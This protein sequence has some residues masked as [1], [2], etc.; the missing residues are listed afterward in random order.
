MMTSKGTATQ[1]V[2]WAVH[3]VGTFIERVGKT[4][5]I[6]GWDRYWYRGRIGDRW[7]PRLSKNCTLAEA[8][9]ESGEEV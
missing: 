1:W 3:T 7:G 5:S 8:W 9:R 6:W 4:L 2:G